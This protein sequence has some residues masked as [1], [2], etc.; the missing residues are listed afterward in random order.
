[1]AGQ[2]SHTASTLPGLPA[3]PSLLAVPAHLCS[4]QLA[5]CLHPAQHPLAST[6]TMLGI[7][8]LFHGLVRER[9]CPNRAH[10]LWHIARPKLVPHLTPLMTNAN[11]TSQAW[12]QDSTIC[13]ANSTQPTPPRQILS[14]QQSKLL[15]KAFTY[16]PMCLRFGCRTLS[17]VMQDPTFS[18]QSRQADPVPCR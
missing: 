16:A 5:R 14:Q 9:C 12:M 13:H 10:V 3:L 15:Q 2:S 6:A 8:S 18:K 11:H 7:L 4:Q 17:T 1:M